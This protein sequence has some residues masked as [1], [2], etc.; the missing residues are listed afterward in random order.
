MMNSRQLYHFL[1]VSEAK[2][3]SAAARKVGVTQPALTRSIKQ[4]EKTL[5]TSLLGCRPNGIVLTP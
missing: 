5:K 3:I 4:L 1:E 2:S